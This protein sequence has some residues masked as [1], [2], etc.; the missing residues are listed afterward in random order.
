[1]KPEVHLGC[2]GACPLCR[3]PRGSAAAVEGHDY[4]RPKKVTALLQRPGGHHG[5]S[6]GATCGE[7]TPVGT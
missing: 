2:P 1:M 4:P 7:G 5:Q 3:P 6:F